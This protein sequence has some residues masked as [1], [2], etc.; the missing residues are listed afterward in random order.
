MRGTTLDDRMGKKHFCHSWKMTV[1][2]CF[3]CGIF[4]QS[5]AGGSNFGQDENFKVNEAARARIGFGAED[6]GCG[7]SAGSQS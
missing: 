1:M 7:H 4:I 3:I 6:L 2:T 5:C